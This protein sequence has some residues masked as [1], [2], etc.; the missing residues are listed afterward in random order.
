MSGDLLFYLEY[1]SNTSNES[2]QVFSEVYEVMCQMSTK[3]HSTCWSYHL[4]LMDNITIILYLF[5]ASH[6]PQIPF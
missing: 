4:S 1:I 3:E 6:K 2:A 5:K